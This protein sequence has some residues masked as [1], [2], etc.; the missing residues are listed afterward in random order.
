MG[1]TLPC[2]NAPKSW[3]EANISYW[4]GSEADYSRLYDYA[5][6]GVRRALPTARVGGPETAG[7]GGQWTRDF[8]E[9]CLHGTNC[10][11]GKI[12]A[13][14]D[15]VSYHAKGSPAFTDGHVRMGIANQLRAI[16]SGFPIIRS[17]P[18]LKD[19][20]IVI[21]ESDP[22]GCAACT[23]GQYGYRNTTLFSSY[24]AASYARTLDLADEQGVNLQGALTWAFE[25]E[26]QP[27]FAGFRALAADGIDLP[28]L[29]VFRM[30]ARMS[31]QRLA[32]QSSAGLDAR[33]ILQSG[34]RGSP[35]VSAL[36][37]LDKNKLA[38]LVWHYHDDDVPG[39]DANVDLSLDN[40][41]LANGDAQ[42][43][44][45]RIDAE[46]SNSYEAWR[47]MGSPLPLSDQ[48]YSELERAGQLAEFEPQKNLRVKDGKLDLNF[49]LPR[50]GVSLLVLTWN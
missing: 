49:A 26:D 1:S 29:N 45:Y 18:E 47:K 39:P 4:H 15:F 50:Q 20:P 36:A 48:Q 42:L 38:I 13:P 43:A 21:G 2:K 25:F 34:V 17:Y 11:T 14:L 30:F 10:A 41:P 23:G 8:L 7:A 32:V 28:V 22:D 33:T 3:N 19:I 44:Q 12:G 24:T 6:D 46:H 37:S 35:D 40:L 16:A 9:H 27:P 31:G 5:A